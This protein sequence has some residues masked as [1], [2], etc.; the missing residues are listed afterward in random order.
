MIAKIALPLALGLAFSAPVTAET[1][2]SPDRAWWATFF[3]AVDGVQPDFDALA[4][5][6]PAFLAATEFDRADVLALIITEMQEQQAAINVPAAEVVISIRA[7]LGD[8]SVEKGGFPVS[9]FTQNMHLKL[10]FN[11]LFFRNWQDFNIFVAT[12]DEGKALRDRIG[13]QALAAEVTV[14]GF[15]KS[16]TRPNAYEAFVTKVAYVAKD[17]LPVAEFTA[18]ETAPLSPTHVADMVADARQRIIEAAG[19]P[20]LGTAWVDAKAQVQQA[21]PFIGSNDFAYTDSG[22]KIAYQFEAGAVVTDEPHDAERPFLVYLQQVDGA[23]RT[24]SGFSVNLSGLDQVDIKGVGPGL[25]CY[26]PSL[27]DRCAVLEFS[28]ADG[29]HI[30]TRAYGVLEMAPAGS[31]EA[32]LKRF[33]GNSIDTF[34]GF[35]TKLGYEP[36]SVKEGQAPKYISSGGVSAYAAGAGA[37]REGEPFYDPLQNTTNIKA[38]NREIALFAVDGAPNRVPIIFVL[39]Q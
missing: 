13:N 3:Q 15:K 8:Y 22:K 27:L 25:A 34:E 17:G 14:T 39:Q 4:R 26:T 1:Y 2:I 37:T 5:K 10:D 28:P 12:K 16:T 30:L 38:I 6:D 35:T 21:Y 11:S 20:T 32:V 33:V 29:G 31:G 36:E 18:I 7:E 19:I 23:W 24:K 9:L